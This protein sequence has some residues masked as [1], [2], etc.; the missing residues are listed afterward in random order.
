MY[1]NKEDIAN[2]LP[3]KQPDIKY[4]ILWFMVAVYP[5]IVIPNPISYFY[6]PRYI[7]LAI[8]SL[9][10]LYALARERVKIRHPVLI[11]LAIFLLLATISTIFAIDP[12]IALGGSHWRFTGLLTYFFCIILFLLASATSEKE[13]IIGYLIGCAAIVSTLGVLQYYGLNLVPHESFRSFSSGYG[14]IGNPNFFGTY[15]V[16]I[17]PAAVLFYLWY[18]KLFWLICSA[19]I[20]A[21][22]LVCMTR[23]VWL[24]AIFPFL[25]LVAYIFKEPDKRKPFMHLAIVFTIVT[26]IIM[27]ANDGYFINRFLSIQTQVEYAANLDEKAGSF[28]FFIWQET[29]KLLPQYWAFGMGSDNLMLAEIRTPGGTLA[30]KVHNIYLEIAITM[31]VFALIAYVAFLV[32]FLKKWRNSFGLLSFT[33][34]ITYL[35]QGFFNIDVVMVMPLFWIILGLTLANEKQIVATGQSCL[36]KKEGLQHFL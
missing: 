32:L 14:T 22:L 30:D 17:L 36:S 11:P 28:R 8:V 13:K 29:V 26:I 3:K 23:G 10:G 16:F 19:A 34:I 6:F 9:L 27:V 1:S 4:L 2:T 20:Y 25:I 18:K 7:I 12:L 15:T 5:L 35:I 33:M 31:G 24:A 21:G